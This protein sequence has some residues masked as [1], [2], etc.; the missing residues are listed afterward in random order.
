[1]KVWTKANILW[2]NLNKKKPSVQSEVNDI[3]LSPNFEIKVFD[4]Q[5]LT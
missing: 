3:I 5:I 4:E 1:M 2:E